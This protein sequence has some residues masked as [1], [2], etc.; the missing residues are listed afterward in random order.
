MPDACPS[1]V[2]KA[3]FAGC[4]VANRRTAISVARKC[5]FY[6]KIEVRV[7][8]RFC[9]REARRA[10]SLCP[11]KAI[12]TNVTCP[13]REVPTH[14]A[15]VTGAA[16]QATGG[17]SLGGWGQG[18]EKGFRTPGTLTGTRRPVLACFASGVLPVAAPRTRF[19][20]GWVAGFFGHYPALSAPGGCAS[21][22]LYSSG[23]GVPI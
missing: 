13:R 19:A 16:E 23:G 5:P 21:G 9:A 22:P 15:G 20:F 10:D 12:S 8:T 2:A 4:Q 18:R 6:F 3:S 14:E 1:R 17:G 7:Q 11:V